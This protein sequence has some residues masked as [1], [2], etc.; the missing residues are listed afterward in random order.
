MASEK[1][2]TIVELTDP[3]YRLAQVS[4]TFHGRDIFAPA[5]AYLAAGISIASLGPE[6]ADPITFPP[7]RLSV[8]GKTVTGEVLHADRF[9]NVITSI[10]RLL[11]QSGQLVLHPGFGI[12]TEGE[13]VF[14]AA[15]AWVELE[16]HRL[17]GIHRT[18]AEVE[19]GEPLALVGSEGYLEIA[20]REG[21]GAQVLG[22]TVGQCVTLHW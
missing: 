1:V 15:K 14:D 4:H 2:E 9:G 8:K 18:Y 16:G 6:V 10:G 19:S 20:V 12:S 7:P 22:L 3:H 17:A 13:L 5:A 11:W 21:D